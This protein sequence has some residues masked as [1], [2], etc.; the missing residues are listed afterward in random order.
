MQNQIQQHQGPLLFKSLISDM[1]AF[2]NQKI[3]HQENL[4]QCLE[5]WWDYNTFVA[6]YLMARLLPQ[7]GRVIGNHTVCDAIVLYLSSSKDT[8]IIQALS[9]VV[10]ENITPTYRKMYSRII[11]NQ[12]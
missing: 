10:E 1:K 7:A 8:Q 3:E 11:L 9:I 12:K 2:S 5:I 6:S 4:M